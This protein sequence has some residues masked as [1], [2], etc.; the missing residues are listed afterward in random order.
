[1]RIIYMVIVFGFSRL[2][3]NIRSLFFSS[4]QSVS[5]CAQC[6]ELDSMCCSELSFRKGDY[7]YLLRQVDK[8]WFL[9]ERHGLIGI[10]PIS[11]VEVSA[12]SRLHVL[13]VL[14]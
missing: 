3:C 1:M 6:I 7:L 8:N 2:T 11:Y 5:V 12:S 4:L 13:D 10:F 9:G 14:Y